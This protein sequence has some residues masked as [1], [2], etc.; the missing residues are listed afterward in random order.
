MVLRVTLNRFEKPEIVSRQTNSK[1]GLV[2]A[3]HLPC[4]YLYF[5]LSLLVSSNPLHPVVPK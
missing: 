2:L 4:P 3:T 5:Y 1:V